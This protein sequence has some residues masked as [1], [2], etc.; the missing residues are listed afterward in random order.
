MTRDR[1]L[2]PVLPPL[3]LDMT[4]GEYVGAK[5]R[6]TVLRYAVKAAILTVLR[7][8]ASHGFVGLARPVWDGWAS[9]PSIQWRLAPGLAE[10][11]FA[12]AEPGDLDHEA[13]CYVAEMCLE[14]AA[15]GELEKRLHRPLK[16]NEDP[17]VAGR[18]EWQFRL[19]GFG[20]FCHWGPSRPEALSPDSDW[21]SLVNKRHLA[22]LLDVLES[23]SD[24]PPYV[25]ARIEQYR[26]QKTGRASPRRVLLF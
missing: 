4:L 5:H 19:P 24:V 13:G 12:Q 22:L 10:C 7:R 15:Q 26:L 20:G 3:L 1:P 14:L 2:S 11:Q 6:E 23:P 9:P 8:A 17:D 16:H 21:Q 25:L 18:Q